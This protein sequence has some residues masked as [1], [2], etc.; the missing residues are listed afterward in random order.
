MKLAVRFAR[1]VADHSKELAYPHQ[2]IIR[3]T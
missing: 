2:D 1:L 3:T